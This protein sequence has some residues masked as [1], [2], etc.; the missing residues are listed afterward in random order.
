[1]PAPLNANELCLSM[2]VLPATCS[3]QGADATYASG[4]MH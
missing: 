3:S 4:S 1:M 2:P